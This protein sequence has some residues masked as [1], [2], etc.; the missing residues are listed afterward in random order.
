MVGD[1]EVDKQCR[2]DNCHHEEKNDVQ[3]FRALRGGHVF[4]SEG[5]FLVSTKEGVLLV[6]PEPSP[7]L[8][9]RRFFDPVL[10]AHCPHFFY[11]FTHGVGHFCACVDYRLVGVFSR[12][13]YIILRKLATS[14]RA[15]SPVST[16]L[17]APGCAERFSEGMDIMIGDLAASAAMTQ[18]LTPAQI[19][20]LLSQDSDEDL[21]GGA[22]AKKER[23]II[24]SNRVKLANYIHDVTTLFPLLRQEGIFSRDDVEII[25]APVT[26]TAKVDKF[27]DVLL[28]KGLCGK[29]HHFR[30]RVRC[31]TR[32][33]QRA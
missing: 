31:H 21:L 28:R 33:F 29:F 1:S 32:C 14:V 4:R 25:E 26:T 22:A 13:L 12:L 6:L 23:E 3:W 5:L 20:S 7:V 8:L 16:G 10:F 9:H 18:S 2:K 24:E 15:F 19:G 27:L 17:K 30:M 11:V